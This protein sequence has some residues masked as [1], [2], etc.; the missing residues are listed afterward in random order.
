ML[1]ENR[2]II[3]GWEGRH[4]SDAVPALPGR[5]LM[6]FPQQVVDGFDRV[7]GDQGNFYEN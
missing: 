6:Y 3:E 4:L 5:L 7:K 1:I 2:N